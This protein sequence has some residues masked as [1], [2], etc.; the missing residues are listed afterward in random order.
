MSDYRTAKHASRFIPDGPYLKTR[1]DI[2]DELAMHDTSGTHPDRCLCGDWD[3]QD[4][5]WDHLADAVLSVI[6]GE[7]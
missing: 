3:G 1:A 7:P 6:Y 4:T 2:A 5:F